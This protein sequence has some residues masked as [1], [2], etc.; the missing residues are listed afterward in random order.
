VRRSRSQDSASCGV[1][2]LRRRSAQYWARAGRRVS[3]CQRRSIPRAG[4]HPWPAQGQAPPQLDIIRAERDQITGQLADAGTR[5]KAGR[6]Y[7]LAALELLRDPKAF[8]DQG[9]T[10]LK[11][12]TNEI[13]FARLHVVGEE[14]SRH[15]LAETVRDVLEA[16]R[17]RWNGE[18]APDPHNASSSAL[19]EDGWV[20][21]QVE[22]GEDAAHV[23]FDRFPLR[24]SSAQMALLERPWAMR[25][26]TL[27]SCAVRSASG[28]ALALLVD[29]P[30]H[31][32]GGDDAAAVGDAPDVG[33]EDGRVADP[34]LEE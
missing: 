8:Y 14:I 34:V 4:G 33:G 11:R 15:E 1:L 28:V 16:E 32:L 31:Q 7:F 18:S 29:Q 13:I 23:R 22:L 2:R 9:G 10:S 6:A 19:K 27:R 21:G 17:S 20:R 26:S 30:G 3:I 12:A 24:C 25:A 5:L